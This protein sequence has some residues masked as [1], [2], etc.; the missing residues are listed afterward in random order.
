MLPACQAYG[1]G[2]L[3]WSLL[4]GGLLGGAL[5]KAKEGR[6]G[7]EAMQKNVEKHRAKLEPWE[8]FCRDLGVEPANIALAWLLANKA[9]TA[10][11]IGPRTIPQLE[12]A[13]KALEIEIT[14]EIGHRLDQIFPGPGGSAP[15]AYAW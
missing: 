4:A 15:E 9:V 8:K 10:P 6:R 11:I 5:E 2:V 7:A 1:L 13:L 14:Q 12:G 3:P